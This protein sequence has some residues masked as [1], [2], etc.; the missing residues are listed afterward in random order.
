MPV[1]SPTSPSTVGFT[2]G[3]AESRGL[4]IRQREVQKE[5]LHIDEAPGFGTSPQLGAS[6][7]KTATS[8]QNPTMAM[9][10]VAQK[11]EGSSPHPSWDTTQQALYL[12]GSHLLI[13]VS[14]SWISSS[15]SLAPPFH[16]AVTHSHWPPCSAWTFVLPFLQC[17]CLC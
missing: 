13:S 5:A 6:V 2:P 3:L 15:L 7:A 14:D 10:T 12:E 8:E 1:L 9:V 17:P 16:P 11:A 4:I